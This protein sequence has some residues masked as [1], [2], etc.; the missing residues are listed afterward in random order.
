MTDLPTLEAAMN[1]ADQDCPLPS[2]AGPALKV[3]RNKIREL[4]LQLLA[5]DRFAREEGADHPSDSHTL[6]ALIAELR[7]RES[8]G[9]AKYGTDVDRADLTNAQ[10]LQHLR[11]ELMDAMLYS[12]AVERTTV[13]IMAE[14][15]AQGRIRPVRLEEEPNSTNSGHGHV[16]PRQDALVKLP[17]VHP[18]DWIKVACDEAGE[19]S[20]TVIPESEFYKCTWCEVCNPSRVGVRMVVCPNCGNKRCLHAYDHRNVCTNSNAVEQPGSARGNV[21]PD[22]KA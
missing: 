3:L 8:V 19:P 10:W 15:A 9:R 6:T 11:E 13:P 18:G 21:N 4:A 2:L 1:L 7:S 14:L 22:P 5:A 17:P 16:R 12:L 20:A